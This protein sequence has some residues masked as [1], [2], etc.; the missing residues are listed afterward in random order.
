MKA[1]WAQRLYNSKEETW[2][3]LPSKHFENCGI[4][5]LLC[6]NAENEKHIPIQ[7]P[8][9]YKDVIKSWHL[10]GGGRKAPQNA[11]DIRKEIIW[12]NKFIQSKG[13][14]LYF[15]NWEES[16]INFIDDLLN[17]N[18]KF[19]S[20]EEIFDKLNTRTNWLIEYNTILKSIPKTWKEK[21]LNSKDMN[22][23]VKKVFKPFLE[24]NNKEIYDLPHQA[25]GYYKLL[26][27]N[28][29]KRSHNENYWNNLFPDRPI[30][31]HVYQNQIKNQK[32]KKLA[33]F[34]FKILHRV[35]PCQE[36]LYQWKIS[37]TNKCRFGCSSV[38]NYNHMF[39][40]CPRLENA[41]T[42]AE[43]IMKCLGIELKLTYKT[44]LFGYKLTYSAYTQ[45]NVLLSHIFFA[46]YKYWIKNDNMINIKHWIFYELKHWQ[47][48][49][50]NMK[51]GLDIM[52]KFITK[53]LEIS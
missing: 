31:T 46:I 50:N 44:L 24:A 49:Y 7:L 48:V 15:K 27:K 13:K 6:M 26:I 19:K 1:V 17:A 5:K 4:E 21:L 39:I 35:L 33:D 2:A 30:W 38:E 18:G 25:R 20:G 3:I 52:N 36:N 23:K 40:T 16:N 9:F 42:H 41:I 47:A 32:I 22:T 45:L 43:K 37:D 14:T 12:G 53:W 8:P 11:L 28:I 34:H 29:C 51:Q 10:C